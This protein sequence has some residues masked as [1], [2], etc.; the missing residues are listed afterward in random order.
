VRAGTP[1]P[2]LAGKGGPT[3]LAAQGTSG[4]S[5]GL[6]WHKEGPD[7]LPATHPTYARPRPLGVARPAQGAGH[8]IRCSHSR[9]RIAGCAIPYGLVSAIRTRKAGVRRADR[10]GPS[11]PGAQRAQRLPSE[12][13]PRLH[14]D[15]CPIPVPGTG[16]E[17][18][19]VRPEVVGDRINAADSADPNRKPYVGGPK[20]EKQLTPPDLNPRDQ[21]SSHD[22]PAGRVNSTIRLASEDAT[23]R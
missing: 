8:R 14:P 5:R 9:R 15:A 17:A 21:W 18:A 3:I 11:R 6:N 20:H 22:Q 12:G 16:L 1:P 19:D 7:G 2:S 13:P 4:Q 10:A 23:A